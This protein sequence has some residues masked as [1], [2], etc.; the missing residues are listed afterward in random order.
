[1]GNNY[2][3][4]DGVHRDIVNL[5]SIA[6]KHFGIKNTST[7]GILVVTNKGD[8]Y[9]YKQ[10]SGKYNKESDRK[11]WLEDLHGNIVVN[12]I[13]INSFKLGYNCKLYDLETKIEYNLSAH[14]SDKVSEKDVE[15]IQELIAINNDDIE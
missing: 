9:I 6:V 14:L 2:T 15:A 4:K 11:D 1:M 13:K 7:K 3:E 5:R 10:C 12:P 8:R